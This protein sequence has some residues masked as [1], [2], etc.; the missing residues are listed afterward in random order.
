MKLTDLFKQKK[1]VLTSEVGPP[2]GWQTDKML[3]ELECV[4]GKVAALNVTDLQS[5][6]MRLGSLV[7]CRILQENKFEPLLQITTRD[8]N[9]ISLESELLG[10]A[11]FG[12]KNILC[13]TGDHPVMG[14]HPDSMPVF[15]LDSV[16]LL[17]S[18]TILMGG[19]DLAGNELE[20]DAPE[21][22]LGCVINP[23][24][25]PLEP[26]LIK[27]EKKIKAGAQF[28]QTQAVYE[29]EKFASF[30]KRVRKEVGDIPVMA[31]IVL[32]KSAGMAKFMNKNVAGVHVPD[33]LIEEMTFPKGTPAGEKKKKSIEIG[34]RLV[35][36]LKPLCQGIH[37]M[38]LGW[39]D[40]VSEI[41]AQSDL[42]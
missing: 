24:A 10:A 26:Q 29:P 1:F 39:D 23:G 38:P 32:L 11:A 17:Q 35:K 33:K 40:C 20:G 25:D 6:A 16:S 31:G 7:T 18:A 34:I 5:A 8:R 12:V 42:K 21:F 4:R 9:R 15:D 22:C 14:D 37:F 28:V 27:L 41:I 36:E 13:L 19:H 3:E 2:K 30:M